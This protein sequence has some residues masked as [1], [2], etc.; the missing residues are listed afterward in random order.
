MSRD[1][2]QLARTRGIDYGELPV[3]PLPDLSWQ[4]IERTVMAE[5][6]RSQPAGQE[7]ARAMQAGRVPV[8]SGRRRAALFGAGALGLAAAAA[9]TL[10]VVHAHQG[11]EDGRAAGNSAA[12]QAQAEPGRTPSRIVTGTAPSAVSLGDVAL[13]VAPKSAVLVDDGRDRGVLVVLERGR[14]QCRVAPRNG[15]PPVVI[16]AGDVRV[17]VI[18][19]EFAVTRIGD[20]ARVDVYH[21]VVKVVQHGRVSRVPA[22][23]SWSGLTAEQTEADAQQDAET[24]AATQAPA[25][26]QDQP[27]HA[28]GEREPARDRPDTS[29][30]SGSSRVHRAAPAAADTHGPA[31]PA[32]PS[33]RE[34]Y[35]RAAQL[36]AS[37]PAASLAT[38][39]DLA[40]SG[41]AWAANALFAEGRLELDLGHRARAHTLLDTYLRR[42]PHGPN[43]QDA[44]SLLDRIE[45]DG[46][47]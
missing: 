13:D 19:T 43:A 18:G 4:R 3:E 25:S 2:N 44:H 35:D 26:T 27:A 6:A 7:Q 41:G 11:T 16:N 47:P 14:V 10:L 8:R 36:E 20:S 24:A 1:K 37:D 17:E 12:V 9:I 39:R 38:Y 42:Y 40:A 5:L 45:Q 28:V 23:Q 34:R 21:G 22:G 30:H 33:D 32:A 46:A 31:Q 15:R 29:R